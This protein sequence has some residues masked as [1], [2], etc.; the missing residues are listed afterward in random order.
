M[1]VVLFPHSV[2]RSPQIILER[3]PAMMNSYKMIFT[4]F[5]LASMLM[6][7]GCKDSDSATPTGT[8]GGTGLFKTAGTFS[9]SSNRGNFS[10]QGIFDTTFMNTSASGAFK[11]TEGRQTVIM[12]FAYNVVSPTN[13]QFAFAGIADT[14]NTTSTGTYSFS[15]A[16][17]SKIAFF[18]YIPNA[19]DTS[20]TA[21]FYIMTGGSFVVTGL[22]A[23][24]I[25]GT[26]SGQGMNENATTQHSDRRPI[27]QLRR[28][29][30]CS[31]TGK[32]QIDHQKTAA[33]EINTFISYKYNSRSVMDR[34][35][36]FYG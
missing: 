4:M 35:L 18:G 17:G 9:F 3:K 21:A 26:F 12:V 29:T 28:R 20:S 30:N 32:D 5:V 22:T 11:Y 14:V 2:I 6:F 33:A 19:A 24:N 34:L 27:F 7:W 8:G 16:S 25:T 13:V 10:A 36:S 31:G 1:N 23:T 15:G